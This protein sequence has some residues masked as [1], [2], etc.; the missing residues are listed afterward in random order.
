MDECTQQCL[1]NLDKPCLERLAFATIED[2]NGEIARAICGMIML[3]AVAD[4]SLLHKF[5]MDLEHPWYRY[6][7]GGSDELCGTC[8][9][10]NVE[11]AKEFLEHL[12]RLSGDSE[13]WAPTVALMVGACEAVQ[14][15]N[16][17]LYSIAG[18]A[19]REDLHKRAWW[20][21]YRLYR[22]KG[23]DR[24]MARCKAGTEG[25]LPSWEDILHQ[26]EDSVSE[27]GGLRR[28]ASKASASTKQTLRSLRADLSHPA[29]SASK[30]QRYSRLSSSSELA[31]PN[32][33]LDILLR[34]PEVPSDQS[35]TF[36]TAAP[37]TAISQK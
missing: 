23:F 13:R 31:E 20:S 37:T 11:Q 19:F 5:W 18:K 8:Q 6:D 34:S 22:D 21:D 1:W 10:E 29:H 12:E 26:Q 7:R 14:V 24:Q 25:E 3:P 17:C 9:R 28:L 36:R 33:A 27:K 30:F 16:D 35:F 4:S 2:E 32:P 15:R